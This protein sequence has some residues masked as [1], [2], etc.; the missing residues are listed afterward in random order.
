M[1]KKEF[2]LIGLLSMVLS[3]V[4]CHDELL[5]PVPESIL[6]TSNAFNTADDIDLT[7]VGVY[8]SL[9]SR[10][11]TDYELMEIASDNMYGAYFATAPGITEIQALN[12]SPENPK[13]NTF[14]QSTYNGIFRA[15]T[16]LANV[17]N[18]DNYADGQKDQFIGEAKFLRAKF[19]FDLVRIFGGV[20]KVTSPISVSESRELARSSETD[21]YMLIVEDLQDAVAKL[22]RTMIS[23]RASKGAAIALLGK[24]YI[25][26]KEYDN[27]KMYF[28]QLFSD[29]NYSLVANF[30]DL[31]REATE[32]NSESIF[33][34]TY[35]AGTNGHNLAYALAA[36]GGVYQVIASGMRVGRPTWDLHK[37]YDKEDSRFAQTITERYLSY[38]EKPGDNPTWYPFFSKW[39]TPV[40]IFNSSG[41]DIPVLRLGDVILLYAE[42]L[43]YSG[44]S[45]EALGQINLIRERAFGD[46]SHNYTL[47]DIPNEEAFLDVLLLERRLELAVENSRW[48]DLVRTGRF[49]TTLT[50][51]EGEYNLST[52]SALII[53]KNAQPYMRYFPIPYEQIQLSAN[54]VMEQNDGY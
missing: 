10:L 27:A 38:Q 21:I 19:Y 53:N 40:E 22:P 49:T 3:L 41:L 16:V 47:A 4:S 24:V 8:N 52:G 43:Y 9:Q 12:V 7:V 11:P 33:S 18:P 50:T 35:V 31:F 44:Q 26:L 30:G 39:L 28:E 37:A 42:A 15:N 6:T 32:E 5:Y 45:Q 25:Y 36:Q 1:N 34:V 54:N 17:D 20:P 46:N 51:I 29:F 48:F 13:L 23:G 14:W 2:Y